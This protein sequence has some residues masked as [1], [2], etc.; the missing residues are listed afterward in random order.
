[1][2]DRISDMCFEFSF[3]IVAIWLA[4][5]KGISAAIMYLFENVII[6]VKCNCYYFCTSACRPV[7]GIFS[8]AER[9]ELMM[10]APSMTDIADPAPFRS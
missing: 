5:G 4:M 1:M 3:M 10:M 8:P 9:Q 6:M 2:L 7:R